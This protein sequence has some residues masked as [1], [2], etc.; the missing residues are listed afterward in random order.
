MLSPTPPPPEASSLRTPRHAGVG[1][2]PFSSPG[3]RDGAA[4]L[5][6]GNGDGFGTS[7]SGGADGGA[8]GPAGKGGFKRGFKRMLHGVPSPSHFRRSMSFQG[9]VSAISNAANRVAT[10]AMTP[11]RRRRHRREGSRDSFEGSAGVVAGEKPSRGGRSGGSSAHRSS[12]SSVD[13]TG[14]A[15]PAE[16]G[17]SS[18]AKV[19][20]V[21][22]PGAKKHKRG[23]TA[24][25][26]AGGGG[27]GEAPGSASQLSWSSSD[28]SGGR[29]SGKVSSS[30]CREKGSSSSRSREKRS[31][32]KSRERSSRGGEKSSS[33][34]DKDRSSAESRQHRH[35]ASISSSTVS[36][37]GGGQRLDASA[38]PGAKSGG[39]D[40]PL[41]AWSWGSPEAPQER[42]GVAG[43]AG[44]AEGDARA[45]HGQQSRRGERAERTDGG[46]TS[47]AT[48]QADV[49]SGRPPSHDGNTFKCCLIVLD[50]EEYVGL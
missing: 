20:A 7:G 40:A 8:D 12:R 43:G 18:T 36:V 10:G 14:T 46:R 27:G 30:R 35:S 19:D 45:R 39:A 26:G 2:L 31:S 3:R 17:R 42:D 48:R 5:D 32:G 23:K 38:V 50:A 49:S 21:L 47:G 25:A 33:R 13:V 15:G 6:I 41:V 4:D 24:P 34:R 28:Q 11:I 9:S 1:A 37:E 16:N 44:D 29:S 22:A